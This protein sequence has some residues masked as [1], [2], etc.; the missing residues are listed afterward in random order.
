MP[1]G[2]GDA[3]RDVWWLSFTLL[4]S[5]GRLAPE[6]C[7]ADR[8]YD[9]R[10]PLP[11]GW[12]DKWFG[13]ATPTAAEPSVNRINPLY[14]RLSCPQDLLAFDLPRA[15]LRESRILRFS[16]PDSRSWRLPIRN[17]EESGG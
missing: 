13:C 5:V 16:T 1:R 3:Q 2:T 11:A 12:R 6:V 15:I 14:L 4:A 17:A 9:S 10:V 8:D 7:G